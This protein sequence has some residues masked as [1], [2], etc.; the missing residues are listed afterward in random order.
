VYTIIMTTYEYMP[1]TTALNHWWNLKWDIFLPN[2]GR[3]KSQQV[4]Q[5]IRETE[6]KYMR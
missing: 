3:S 4:V 5:T 2:Q 1:G 6:Q